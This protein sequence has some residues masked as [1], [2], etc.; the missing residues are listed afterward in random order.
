MLHCFSDGRA[1]SQSHAR[2]LSPYTWT[3][4]ARRRSLLFVALKVL[5]S[6]LAFSLISVSQRDVWRCNTILSNHSLNSCLAVTH[7]R[8][9]KLQISGQIPQ[10]FDPKLLQPV[11]VELHRFFPTDFMIDDAA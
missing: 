4:D 9:G 7:H 2:E 1:I 10:R 11:V 8:F 3:A 6:R 5:V